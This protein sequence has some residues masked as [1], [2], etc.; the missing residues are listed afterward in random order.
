MSNA[1]VT[2]CSIFKVHYVVFDD[3]F[4]VLSRHASVKYFFKKIW[5]LEAES[6]HRHGDFQSPALPTELSGH[7]CIKEMG[8]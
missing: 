2:C 7:F 1:W 3:L 6:N 4:I 5:C 8:V